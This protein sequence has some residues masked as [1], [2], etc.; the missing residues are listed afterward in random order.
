MHTA[1]PA[2]PPP[3]W[4]RALAAMLSAPGGAPSPGRHKIGAEGGA[5]AE[6]DGWGAEA[7]GEPRVDFLFGPAA[8][9]GAAA[10]GGI[11]AVPSPPTLTQM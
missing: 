11:G 1:R 3:R 10:G 8:A 6:G 2:P 7:V 9:G 5:T 4:A